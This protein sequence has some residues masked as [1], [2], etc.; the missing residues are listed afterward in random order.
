MVKMEDLTILDGCAHDEYYDPLPQKMTDGRTIYLSRNDFGQF[1]KSKPA[2]LVQIADFGLSVSGKTQHSGCIQAEVYRA[3]EVI[4]DAGYSYSADIWSLGVMMWD[5]V[6]G[7]GLLNPVDKRADDEYDDLVHLAQ[8]TSLLGPPPPHLLSSG[9]RT[10][11]F[12][13]PDGSLKHREPFPGELKFEN[14]VTKI[15]GQEKTRFL[16]FV[17]KMVKWDPSERSTARDLLRDRWLYDDCT[18][19]C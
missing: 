12:Y 15:S 8:L 7:K 16:E 5:L 13:K 6:E 2:G 10:S 1:S 3:P 9:Q 19:D 18:S 17:S 11:M 4:L 14:T